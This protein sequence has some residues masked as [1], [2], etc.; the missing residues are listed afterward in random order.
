M[1]PPALLPLQSSP[2]SQTTQFF[3]IYPWSLSSCC[4]GDGAQSEWVYQ[5]KS[6]CLGPLRGSCCSL[7]VLHLTH[8]TVS[9][10]FHSH[11]WWRLLFSTLV[12]WAGKPCVG[13]GP[14]ILCGD[15]CILW[16]HFWFSTATH[17]C[18]TS[19]FLISAPPNQ[20]WYD[21]CTVLGLESVQ[22]NFR[23]LSLMIVL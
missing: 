11:M 13:L 5:W 1:A 18:G 15:L 20:S 23:W 16:Y 3:S 4:P 8:V 17:E 14:L 19:S 2:Q 9:A 22:L 7:A 10:G 6:L 12:L 21:F